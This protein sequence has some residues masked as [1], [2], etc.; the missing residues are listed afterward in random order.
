MRDF[1]ER[2][3]REKLL[4]FLTEYAEHDAKFAN[5]VNVRFCKPEFEDELNK[6]EN[7][8]DYALS[9]V[10]DYRKRDSWGNVSIYTGDITEEIQQRVSQGHI[11]LA[12]AET[13]LLYRKLLEVFEY[14]GECEISYEAEYCLDMMSDIAGKVVLEDDKEYIFKHCLELSR[15]EDGKNYGADYEDKLLRIAAKFV[16]TEN[17]AELEQALTSFDGERRAEEFKLI[18]LDLIRKFEGKSATD[19]FIADNLRFPKIREIAFDKAISCKDYAEAERLCIDALSIY[20]RHYGVSP[21]LYKLYSVYDAKGNADDM[22]ETAKKI[23]I[24]G[25]MAYYEKL[26]SQ[27]KK[28]GR[29]ESQYELLLHEFAA[30]LRNANYMQI[31][32]KEQEHSLLLEQLK[33]HTYTVYQYGKILAPK[34]PTDIC[35]IFTNQIKKEAEAAHKRDMYRD[36]CSHINIFSKVGYT[37]EAIELVMELKDDYRRKPAFVDELAKI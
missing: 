3:N 14:Q 16:T 18:H 15:L 13:E 28:Q 9:D 32:E 5:A 24:S 8:I 34:Y 25:D 19:R 29:W 12:F 22:V 33:K 10:S 27:L 23:L 20:T 2:L 21:W 31:L 37:A 17:R 26:K 35:A 6:I 7:E 4:D 11:R 1:F 30:K 36:V